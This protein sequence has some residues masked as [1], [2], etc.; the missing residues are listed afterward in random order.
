MKTKKLLPAACLTI[1]IGI[2]A[3]QK[4]DT[5][6][7]KAKDENQ[8]VRL[9]VSDL[10]NNTMSLVTPHKNETET[11]TSQFAASTIYPTASG[12]FAAVLNTANNHVQF[13]DSGIEAHGE[14]AHMKGTPKWA[15]TIADAPRPTHVYSSGNYIT[16]FNDG[17]GSLSLITEEDLHNVEKATHLVVDRPHHGAAV[18]FTNGTFAVTEKDNS[19]SGSLPER[20]KILDGNGAIVHASSVATGGIHGEGSNGTMALFGSVNGILQVNDNG[21]Q[22][23]IPYP[24][25][26]GSKWIGTVYH[27]K[28]SDQF[29]GY[30][31]KYGVYFISPENNAISPVVE[32][33]NIVAARFDHEGKDILVLQ[34]DGTLMVFDGKL[35]AKKAERKLSLVFP[36]DNKIPALT[37]SKNYVYVTNPQG[38]EVLMLNKDNLSDFR[39]FAIPGRPG[40]ISLIGADVSEES[41]D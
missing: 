33:E 16:I 29:V 13:F 7:I 12:R 28:A 32:S 5:P 15:K 34:N 31:S 38:A 20:V 3:C 8:F 40:R 6:D 9:L 1:L 37:A 18:R 30:I 27:G 2:S 24:A 25:S 26:F 4:D 22:R 11:F 10:D 39:K 36:A 21:S 35:G 23:L 41:D 19:V 14:H 17:D